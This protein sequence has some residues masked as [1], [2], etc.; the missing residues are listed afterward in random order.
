MDTVAIF[1][2]GVVV[3]GLIGLIDYVR[4][5]RRRWGNNPKDATWLK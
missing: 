5:K 3:I 4:C 1:E 2:I